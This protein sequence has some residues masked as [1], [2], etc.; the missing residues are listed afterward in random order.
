MR[1]NNIVSG[2]LGVFNKLNTHQGI[3]SQKFPT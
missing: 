3:G 2:H 1:R